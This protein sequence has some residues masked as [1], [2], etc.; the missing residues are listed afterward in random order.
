MDLE[1]DA[2]IPVVS[3]KEAWISHRWI[4]GLS[5]TSSINSSLSCLCSWYALDVPWL[6]VMLPVLSK[7]STT[8]H[9]AL[10]FSQIPHYLL[11]QPFVILCHIA[12]PHRKPLC[13]LFHS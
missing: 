9:T 4:E 10:R 3:N 2:N 7:W 6:G 12:N 8:L 11:V 13:A 5:H 1:A